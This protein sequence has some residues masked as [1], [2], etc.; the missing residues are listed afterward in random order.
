MK[1][2]LNS[3][4][5]CA[6]L[7]CSKSKLYKL[8]HTRELRYVKYGGRIWF[9]PDDLQTYIENHSIEIR[10]REDLEQEAADLAIGRNNHA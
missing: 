1:N 6:F 4:K 2:R 7:G 5:A 9:K 10:S 3:S 8:T